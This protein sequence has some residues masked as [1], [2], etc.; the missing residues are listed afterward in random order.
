MA[1]REGHINESLD[2]SDERYEKP[3]TRDYD[4]GDRGKSK[5]D[6]GVPFAIDVREDNDVDGFEDLERTPN[7]FTDAIEKAQVSDLPVSTLRRFST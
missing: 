4:D 7:T 3:Q 2:L 6:G 5:D 1:Q